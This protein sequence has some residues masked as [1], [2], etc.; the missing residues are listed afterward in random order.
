MKRKIYVG[1][2]VVLFSVA[3]VLYIFG[4]AMDHAVNLVPVRGR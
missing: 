3:P 4:A 2:H 1:A